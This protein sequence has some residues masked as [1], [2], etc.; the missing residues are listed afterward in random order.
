MTTPS[1]YVSFTGT[2]RRSIGV[3]THEPEGVIGDPTASSER[4]LTSILQRTDWAECTRIGFSWGDL[5]ES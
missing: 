3:D 5:L 4:L 1:G 2:V